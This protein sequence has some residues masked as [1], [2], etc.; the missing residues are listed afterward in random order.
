MAIFMKVVLL[1]DVEKLGKRGQVK[2]VAEGYARNFLFTQKLA[3]LATAE[4]MRHIEQVQARVIK[5]TSN[6]EKA[7]Q[8]TIRM[9]EGRSIKISAKA[10]QSGTLYGGVGARD[11]AVAL[12]RD[13]IVVEENQI[14]VP[15]IK[16]LGSY[17]ATVDFG[18]GRRATVRVAVEP[19]N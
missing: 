2:D 11:V 1:K 13:D 8:K 16:S 15:H 3:A 9:L 18:H 14:R 19:M 7:I 17:S 6:Q 4:T 10:G 12:K 5:Q